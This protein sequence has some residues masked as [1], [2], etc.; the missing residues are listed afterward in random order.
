MRYVYAQCAVVLDT[1]ETTAEL[2]KKRCFFPN[3]RSPSTV[4]FFGFAPDRPFH[5][6]K[7]SPRAPRFTVHQPL[8]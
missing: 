8:D 5:P 2:G 4:F 1:S 7:P 6:L 3:Y